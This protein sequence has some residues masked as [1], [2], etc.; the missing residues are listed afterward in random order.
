MAHAHSA[1][2]GRALIVVVERDPH[3]RALEGY[4]L[5][6]AGFTVEF[7]EDGVT[8]LERVRALRPDI[9]IA[10]ILVR[11]LDGL[12]L[13]RKVKEAPETRETSVLIFSILLSSDR[14]AEAGADA[15]VRKPLEDRALIQS[16]EGL[17][18]GERTL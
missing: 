18:K 8:A 5:E 6:R 7:C 9:V 2:G 1:R 14:A 16:V 15:F 12:T 4:F 11:G 13:C 3:V 17:L 10:E